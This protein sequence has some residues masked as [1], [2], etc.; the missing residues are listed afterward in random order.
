MHTWTAI[1]SSIN[2][3]SGSAIREGLTDRQDYAGRCNPIK[4]GDEGRRW[5]KAELILGINVS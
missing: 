5:L 4:G 2:A 1:E 3:N